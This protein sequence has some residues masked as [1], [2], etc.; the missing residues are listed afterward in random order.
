MQLAAELE[1]PIKG[2]HVYGYFGIAFLW[3]CLVSRFVNF[4]DQQELD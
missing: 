1:M 3:D 2:T 4:S